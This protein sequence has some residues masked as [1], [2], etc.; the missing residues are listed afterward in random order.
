MAASLY[1]FPQMKRPMKT[2]DAEPNMFDLLDRAS[3]LLT[4]ATGRNVAEGQLIKRTL[5]EHVATDA[6]RDGPALLD[7]QIAALP[8]RG[9]EEAAKRLRADYE[10][11]VRELLTVCEHHGIPVE[12][13]RGRP[14]KKP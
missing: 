9:R 3:A 8:E 12:A 1:S 2:F 4:K 13:P 11:R 7:A 5:L 14:R 6:L 10:L